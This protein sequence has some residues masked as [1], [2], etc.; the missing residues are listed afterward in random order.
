MAFL[1]PTVADFK[2]YFFRDFPY[3]T[4][5]ETQ[6]LDQDIAKAFQQVNVNINQALFGDQSSYTIGYLLMSA[7]FLV[8]NLR[9]SSQGLNGSYAFLEN[10]KSVGNV[11]QGFSI[12]QRILDNP[13]WA[14]LMT[15]SYGAE[16]LMMILPQ[17][18]GQVFTVLGR[19]RA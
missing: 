15:T 9:A 19:T 2:S 11:S 7:H 16:F 3:G 17:L 6:V 13:Y 1:N 10:S 18:C 8:I 12:P 5:V 14:M 4:D